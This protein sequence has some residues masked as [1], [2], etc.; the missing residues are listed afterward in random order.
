MFTWCKDTTGGMSCPPLGAMSCLYVASALALYTSVYV[1]CSGAVYVSI[2]LVLREQGGSLA[3]SL[4]TNLPSWASYAR[5]ES[6]CD[7]LCEAIMKDAHESCQSGMDLQHDGCCRAL[8][9]H[10]LCGTLRALAVGG[11]LQA[12]CKL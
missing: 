10:G 1:W 3:S 12:L 8:M 6:D 9:V 5:V 7:E 4:E 11:S 2:R